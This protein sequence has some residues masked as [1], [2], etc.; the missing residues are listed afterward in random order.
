MTI[1]SGFF[2]SLNHD[3]VYDADDMNAIFDG[4]ITDGVFGNIGGKFTVTPGS[5][6]SVNVGTGKAR[7]HQI[8][9]ENDANLVLQ[10]SQSDVLLNRIDVVAIRVDKTVNGRL[11]NIVIVKGSPS[12][13]PVAP[14]LSSDNQIWEMPI[15][16]INIKANANVINSSDIQYLVGRNSTPLITA[17]MQTINLES[18][19]SYLESQ[20]TEWFS[21][22][23]G[24]LSTDAAGNLQN[25][26]NAL[27]ED[28]S[29]GADVRALQNQMN[30]LAPKISKMQTE[31]NSA[32]NAVKGVT[33][34]FEINGR[35]VKAKGGFEVDE[36]FNA[37]NGL[38]I[39]GNDTLI[40]RRFAGTNKRDFFRPD[41]NDVAYISIQIAVPAGY[42][43]LGAMGAYTHTNAEIRLI[44][45]SNNNAFCSVKN[46]DGKSNV[47]IRAEVDVLFYRCE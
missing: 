10:V 41:A 38:I 26:I 15:A 33:D 21:I 13:N 18:Y 5:G 12:Q 47:P 36:K 6:M 23:K 2:N 43:T 1:K 29:F 16:Y 14:V 42:K 7:F 31:I 22:I 3:R 19:V 32:N 27:K 8:F 20:F 37:K 9:V 4:I 45:F 35:N 44:G 24:K 40:V 25:Q 46:P 11:G 34:A 17:P 28:S 39:G 30:L